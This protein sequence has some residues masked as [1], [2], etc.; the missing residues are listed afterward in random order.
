ML[1]TKKAPRISAPRS[2]WPSRCIDEGLKIIAQ[3]SVIS[4]RAPSPCGTM[5]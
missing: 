4:A 2:T 5:W 3:K 1:I